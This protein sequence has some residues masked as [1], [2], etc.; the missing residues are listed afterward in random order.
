MNNSIIITD[1]CFRRKMI[2]KRQS[3]QM[4]CVEEITY[5]QRFIDARQL[6]K[7]VQTLLKSGYVKYL[8]KLLIN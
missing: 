8:K 3:L 4:G 2:E 6:E 1:G 5:H 7:V